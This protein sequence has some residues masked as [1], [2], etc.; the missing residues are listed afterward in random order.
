MDLAGA[1]D[2]DCLVDHQ[3]DILYDCFA[4]ATTQCL[5]AH[6]NLKCENDER[7]VLE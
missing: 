7:V 1:R 4:A 3:E 2:W 5:L 6:Q